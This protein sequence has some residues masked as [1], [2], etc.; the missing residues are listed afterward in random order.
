MAGDFGTRATSETDPLVASGELISRWSPTMWTGRPDEDIRNASA[1]SRRVLHKSASDSTTAT[2]KA[3]QRDSAA[4]SLNDVYIRSLLRPIPPE[5]AGHKRKKPLK[6]SLKR[7]SKSA[8]ATPPSGSTTDAS[9]PTKGHRLRRVKTVDFEETEARKARSLPPFQPWSIGPSPIPSNGDIHTDK[10]KKIFSKQQ[11]EAKATKPRRAFPVS[12]T[13]GRVA[14]CAVTRTDV[15]V[16]ALAPNQAPDAT[17]K[18]GTDATPTMQF[19]ESS[20]GRI[21]VVWDD[22]PV[23]DETRYSRRAS[24]A[25]QAL[26]QVQSTRGRGLEHVNSKL[27]DWALGREGQE[28]HFRPQIVVFPDE[29]SLASRRPSTV[30]HNSRAPVGAPPNSQ[31]TSANPSRIPSQTASKHPSRH[32]SND[33]DKHDVA[34]E[35]SKSSDS[36]ISGANDNVRMLVVPDPDASLASH[37]N[38]SRKPRS[39]PATHR[40]SDV[41]E[42][43]DLNHFH[44]HRDSVTLARSRIHN[45]GGISPDLFMHRDSVSMA[46]KRMH[47][48]NHAISDA[49]QI[50]KPKTAQEDSG[51]WTDEGSL[52]SPNTLKEHAV[53]ALR[54][55]M[56][57]SIL[58]GGQEHGER[59]IRIVE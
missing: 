20:T 15:H 28:E 11:K 17:N 27:T 13:K 36:E 59:H 7:Q 22:V 46:K 41:D 35:E 39:Y 25:S 40:A 18:A 16:V 37:P 57:T 58:R 19:V 55:S 50:S 30:A 24:S 53:S 14:D 32:G 26:N 2:I 49:L 56:S 29:D 51:S 33:E 8:A 3:Q 12:K 43:S 44:G 54:G 9:I 23:E 48:R 5:P 38:T 21:E 4:D 6:S 45:S 10:V 31:M 42:F 1:F 47:A 52:P 34:V